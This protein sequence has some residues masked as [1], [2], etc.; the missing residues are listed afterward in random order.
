MRAK[1]AQLQA[2]L[3]GIVGEH[4]RLI[5]SQLL[6]E[7]ELF[8]EQ[9]QAAGEFI[10]R[11]LG[12]ERELIDRLDEIPGINQRV[13]EVMEVGTDMSRFPSEGHLISWAGLCPGQNES[14]G[15]R[16]KSPVRKGNRAL[17]QALLEA[18]H[19][20]ARSR[21]YLAAMCRRL[22]VRRGKKRAVM[23]VARTLLATAYHM[24]SR[25]TRYHDVGAD[26]FDRLQAPRT[27]KR[28]T[29]R[30]SQLG[31]DATL[32]PAFSG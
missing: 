6:S 31:Y 21:G 8:E 30:L 17:K 4:H 20:A 15:K 26:Y 14:A 16:K 1:N 24:I 12:A 9:I 3:V 13:A 19:G 29:A 22:T 23:A 25:G 28:L 2:A 32:T 10:E 11:R 7:I 18:A 27:I 5:L